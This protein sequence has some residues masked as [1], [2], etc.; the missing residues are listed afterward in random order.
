MLSYGTRYISSLTSAFFTEN[1]IILVEGILDGEILKAKCIGH[2]PLEES[3]DKR[4]KINERD[5]F[6]A[7]AKKK[8][9]KT[10]LEINQFQINDFATSRIIKH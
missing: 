8:M 1:S 5:W 4:F 2:P 6:G 7:Y 10:Q 3:K 9:E